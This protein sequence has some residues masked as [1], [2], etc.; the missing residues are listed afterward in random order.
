MRKILLTSAAAL[1]LLTASPA[2]A[3]RHDGRD[4][5]PGASGQAATGTTSGVSGA[6]SGDH[7]GSRGTHSGGGTVGPSGMGAPSSHTGPS[8]SATTFGAGSASGSSTGMGAAGRTH[9]D[10]G[11]DNTLRP[12]GQSGTHRN[13]GVNVFGPTDHRDRFDR[14][15]RGHEFNALRGRFNARHRFQ[16][17]SYHRPHGWYWHRW[18]YGEFLPAFFFTSNYWINDWD[19]FGLYDPPPGCVWVRYGNDALLIDQYTG[20]VIQVVYGIFY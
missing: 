9:R 10:R 8:G 7:W 3:E 6:H 15:T 2:L 14:G 1:A 16:Y 13:S 18:N 17:G 5:G 20:E 19:Y 11:P 4:T 12:F